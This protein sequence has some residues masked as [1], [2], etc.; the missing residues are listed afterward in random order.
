MKK[1]T[2][3]SMLMLIV[4]LLFGCGGEDGEI[5]PKSDM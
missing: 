5:R 1:E 4:V 3:F 2:Y